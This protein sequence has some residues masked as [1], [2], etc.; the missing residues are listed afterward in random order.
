[1]IE[2]IT[3]PLCESKDHSQIHKD[4]LREYLSCSDCAFVFVPKSY[5]LS[6]ADEKLRYDTHNNDPMDVRYRQFLSQLTKPLLKKI[7]D[8][9]Y[10]LDFGSGPGPTLSLMLQEKGHQLEIYD[11]FYAPN[12]YIFNQQFDFITATEVIE[13]LRDPKFEFRR[14]ASILKIGGYLSLMTQ[15]LTQEID[16][17]NWYY[18]NDPSHIGF[19][20]QK[21][22]NYVAKELGFEINV[23]SERVIFL[24][25]LSKYI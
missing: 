16:F 18:K 3:C 4:S 6:E 2:V 5:H 20:N 23:Y 11:K 13:H 10:G 22:L 1:M 9:S 7:A 15:L 19:F 25:K 21:S 14:L 12:E 17:S 8:D 24:K